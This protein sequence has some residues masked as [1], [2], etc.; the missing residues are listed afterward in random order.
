MYELQDIDISFTLEFEDNPPSHEKG[1]HLPSTK[2]ED[3]FHI[4]KKTFEISMKQSSFHRN[5]VPLHQRNGH[6]RKQHHLFSKWLNLIK[7]LGSNTN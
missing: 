5:G 1:L 3:L 7:R 4:N 2:L 6:A